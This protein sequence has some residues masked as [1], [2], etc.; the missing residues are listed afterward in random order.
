MNITAGSMGWLIRRLGLR[1]EELGRTALMFLYLLFVLLAYY[2]LKPV[3]RALFL[4]RFDASQ[5]PFLYLAMAVSGGVL[6]YH[7][8]R[9]AVRW[10]LGAAGECGDGDHRHAARD[11]AVAAAGSGLAVLRVQHLGE[12]V[13]PGAG[14]P[15]VAGGKPCLRRAAAK[16]VYSLLAAG[17][18]LGAA[19]G[20]SFTALVVRAVGT[21]NLVPVSALFVLLAYGCYRLL[22]AA[23]WR[24]LGEVRAAEEKP[25]EFTVGGV[26]RDVG[27]NRHLQVIIALLM[28]TYV[29]DTLVEYQFSSMARAA[30][31]G[32][33]LTAFLGGFYGLY[34]NLGD[35]RAAGISDFAGREPVRSGR[36][37]AG[38]AGGHWR[39]DGGDGG[40]AGD[41][42]GRGSRG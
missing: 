11:L 25:V 1:R 21:A 7:Y 27:R 37:A 39:G 35:V 33:R 23:A 40:D 22:A 41:L 9:I 14:E 29:V 24:L 5:L 30:Y 19:L 31:Q 2:I 8:V 16:R 38:D 20:G 15:G 28:V 26:A 3:S 34:L 42:G 13:Q 18:V 4:T 6:A 32:D 10:S 17:A 36:H 12:P